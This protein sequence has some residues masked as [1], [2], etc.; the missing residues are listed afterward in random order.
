M[1][2]RLHL[3]KDLAPRVDHDVTHRSDYFELLFREAAAACIVTDSA[4]MVIDANLAA[5]TILLWPVRLM[6]QQPFQHLISMSDREAFDAIAADMLLHAFDASRPLC[7]K[8]QSGEE[9]DVLFRARTIRRLDGTAEF[10]SWV[11]LET[12]GPGSVELV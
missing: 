3:M 8:P 2:N 9:I 10:I 4:C 7:M 1:K 11:F 6:R 5:E 12:P